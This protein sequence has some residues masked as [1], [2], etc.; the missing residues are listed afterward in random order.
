MSVQTTYLITGMTCGH[1][2]SAVT[3][4]LSGL[5]GVSAVEVDLSTG[6]ALV[7]SDAAL[8]LDDVRSA[9]DE[10]GYVLAGSDA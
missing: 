1:C 4:E 2:V 8:P 6:S 9:V 10:A 5:P 7:T 3:G